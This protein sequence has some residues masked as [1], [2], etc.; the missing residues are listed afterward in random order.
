VQVDALRVEQPLVVADGSAGDGVDA[1]ELGLA[2]E[3]A[4]DALDA[5]QRHF[6]EHR[7]LDLLEENV[8]LLLVACSG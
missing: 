4:P 8:I 6:G 1:V 5:P 3:D 7:R 2:H